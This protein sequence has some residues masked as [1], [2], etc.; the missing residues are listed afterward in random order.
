MRL[1]HFEALQ[2]HCPVCFRKTGE[3]RPLSIGSEIRREG[4][5]LIEGVLL[6]PNASCQREYPVLDG[7]PLL[8]ANLRE[9]VAD[10]LF[11]LMMRDDLSETLESILGDCSGPASYFD[12]TRHQLSCYA[13]DH[14]GLHDPA[15]PTTEPRP[16]AATRVLDRGLDLAATWPEGPVVDLGCSVGGTTF[17]LADR[18][19]R[20]VVGVD[21]NIAM[22]RT[23]SHALLRGEVSYPRKRTGVVYDRRRFPVSFAQAENVDFWACDVA[24]L[25]F[26]SGTFALAS[27][28]NLIDCVRAP[29][30]MLVEAA[31]V[32]APGAPAVITSPYDWSAAATPIETWLGGHSQRGSAHGD[33]ATVLR[34]LLAP[35]V[36]DRHPASIP[37]LRL[38]S[39]IHEVPWHV[40][41]HDRSTVGYGV[42]LV[43]ARKATTESP[44]PVEVTG[45]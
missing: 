24:A 29:R 30:D 6:C 37:G 3:P 12:G 13:R 4:E 36:A 5:V 11:Q 7:I 17:A 34:A 39:E 25:P 27:V 20:L 45:L 44:V 16:G 15:E 9:L 42:H 10:N 33:G 14:Y 32:L 1:R 22:L 8:V 40:R 2:P 26:A 31:R 41:L 35:L 38:E 43:A 28:L 19:G 23:A 18:T 21:L